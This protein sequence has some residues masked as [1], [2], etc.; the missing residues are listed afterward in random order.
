MS[1]QTI[2]HYEIVQKVGAGGMGVVYKARD[3]KLERI[4]ALKFLPD[5]LALNQ[6]EKEKL[7]REARAASALDHPNIGAIYGLEEGPD[8]PAFIV[9]AFYEGETLA[10]VIDHHASSLPQSLEILIQ[11]ARGLAAAHTR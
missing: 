11:V 1:G 6:R 5:D 10:S 7:L 3:L 8:H 4:V 2:A 9:M